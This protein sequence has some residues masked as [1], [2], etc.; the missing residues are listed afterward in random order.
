MRA[1]IATMT[2]IRHDTIVLSRRLDR[3]RA[4]VFAAFADDATRRRWIRM[5]G[6]DATYRHDFRVGGGEDAAS[7]FVFPDGRTER[8]ANRLRYLDIVPDE[9]VVMVSESIVDD[10]L[11]WAALTTVELA[12]DDGDSILSWTEQAAFTTYS[13]TGDD[14]LAHLRGGISLRLNGLAAALV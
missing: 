6:H 4:S 13:G 2:P 3:P 11:R 5:P 12:D 1:S 7:T 9:R 8:L 14:D 10:V